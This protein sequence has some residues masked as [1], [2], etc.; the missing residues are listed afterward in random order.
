[1]CLRRI[2]SSSQS[3][4]IFTLLFLSAC[5]FVHSGAGCTGV[6]DGPKDING[7]S[8]QDGGSMRTSIPGMSIHVV[9]TN[10]YA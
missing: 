7:F 1:M 4:F 9:L 8:Q 3:S 10:Y 5:Y 2:L 6:R